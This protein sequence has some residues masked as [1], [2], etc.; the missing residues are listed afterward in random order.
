MHVAIVY[1]SMFGNTHAIAKAIAEGA[2]AG[3]PDVEVTVLPVA[4]ATPAA[5][6]GTGLL[7]AGGP[8][9]MRTMTSE[10]TRRK[11]LEEAVVVRGWGPGRPGGERAGGPGG[12][13]WLGKRPLARRGSLAAAFGTRD[14]SLFCGGAAHA[15]ARWRQLNGYDLVAP[16]Y[17]FIVWGTEGQLRRGETAKA[18]A[19]GARVVRSALA[20]RAMAGPTTLHRAGP[21]AQPGSRGES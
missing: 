4:D 5:F 1:E 19:W 10:L 13:E 3:N 20:W 18:R 15:I 12:R 2:R 7:V 6:S 9:H 14:G 16:P 21:R 11:G 8:T 17:G